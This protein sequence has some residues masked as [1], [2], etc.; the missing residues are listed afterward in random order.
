[1]TSTTPTTKQI[2]DNIIAQLEA[3]L[4]QAIPL[5]PKAFLRVLAKI[6]AAVFVMLYKYGGFV[7]LQIFVDTAANQDTEING[8]IVNP[9]ISWG[10][11]IGTGNPAPATNAEL[12]INVAVTNQSGF[13]PS[14]AQLIN[15]NN[16]VTYLTLGSVALDSANIQVTIKAVSDQSGGN[17]QG[18]IGNLQ[19]NDIV[20]FANPL[21][22]ISRDA[23]VVSQ[24]V[25]GA[26]GETTQA[27]RQRITDRF[28]KR[29]QGGAYADYELWG[30]EP[31][32]ILNIYPYTGNPGEVNIYVEATTQSSGNADGIP[33][34]AQLIEVK[35]SIELDN[36]GI[37]TR[38]PINSFVN[39]F[40]IMRAE[41]SVEISGLSVND[42][43]TIQSQI[44]TAI[45]QY[46]FNA[47]PFI[48]GLTIPPRTDIISRSA[49]A[50]IVSNIVSAAGGLFTSLI[51]KNADNTTIEV[52]SLQEGEKAKATQVSFI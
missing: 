20:S 52:Y 30:E 9:L 10:R 29:P 46:F 39:V 47:Q 35:K 3:S 37:A 17:G 24:S 28:Q 2:N 34:N 5:L 4:N 21:P 7:F 33:T 15:A 40:A 22:N 18:T 38:R 12:L 44:D 50:G 45:K 49:V 31:A 42:P 25:T 48:T 16:G 27:Y 19:V 6:F 43:A 23:V 32:G 26:D 51:V 41:F 8:K 13:L 36:N 14:N 11:L 1:M